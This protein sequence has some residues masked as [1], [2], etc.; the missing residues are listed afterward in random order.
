GTLQASEAEKLTCAIKDVLESAI[1]QGGTTLKDFFSVDGKPGY[2]KQSLYVYGRANL[3]C[4]RCGTPL[5]SIRI[6]Q[7]ATVYC[8]HCQ[9]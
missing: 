1:Q 2:F 7:R 3:P 6:Q 5:S 4:L 8:C 9:R